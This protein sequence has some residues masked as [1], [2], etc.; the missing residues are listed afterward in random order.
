MKPDLSAVQM[1]TL[2]GI[3]LEPEAIVDAPYADALDRAVAPAATVAE[4]V[5]IKDA[6]KRLIEAAPDRDHREAARV[7]YYAAVAA[8][9]VRHGAL[10]SSR[11]MSKQRP[12][13]ER[14]AI[15]LRSDQ[16]RALFREAAARLASE[17]PE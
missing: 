11:A 15:A 3:A 17:P 10:I 13:F 14:L 16:L 12:L 6:A 2:L 1:R 9:F 7:V 8:A 5:E 4:L